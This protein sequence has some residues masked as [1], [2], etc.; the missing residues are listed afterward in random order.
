M[1]LCNL[2]LIFVPEK[3]KLYLFNHLKPKK[4]EKKDYILFSFAIISNKRKPC[5][6]RIKDYKKGVLPCKFLITS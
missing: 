5:V 3:S 6:P 2:L 4:Y 1:V